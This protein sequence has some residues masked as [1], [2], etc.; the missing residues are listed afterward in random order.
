MLKDVPNKRPFKK[1][2]SS[3]FTILHTP[4]GFTFITIILN[5]SASFV[6]GSIDT[7]STSSQKNSFSCMYLLGMMFTLCQV[8]IVPY[9]PFS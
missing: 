2:P 4:L 6:Y 1:F 7:T 5:E 3:L 9:D 8:R